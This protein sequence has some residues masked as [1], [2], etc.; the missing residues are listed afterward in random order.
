MKNLIPLMAI[1]LM[2]TSLSASPAL[3]GGKHSGKKCE[4]N[5]KCESGDECCK[6]KE[7]KG[8][9][10]AKSESKESKPAESKK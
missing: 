2:S 6:D 1:L 8:E 10:K 4:K 5:A 3:A 9:S 7:A